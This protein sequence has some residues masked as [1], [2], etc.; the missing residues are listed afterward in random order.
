MT[1]TYTSHDGPLIEIVVKSDDRINNCNK[2]TTTIAEEHGNSSDEEMEIIAD[3]I[4][5]V[6]VTESADGEAFPVSQDIVPAG[7]YVHKRSSSSS[8]DSR[9]LPS[10][11]PSYD[12]HTTRSDRFSFVDPRGDDSPFHNVKS[13]GDFQSRLQKV[14]ETV[15]NR[16]LREQAGLSRPRS[17]IQDMIDMSLSKKKIQSSEKMLRT[18]F[19]EFY[20]GLGLLKSYRLEL[21]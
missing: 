6:E 9:S 11:E 3:F 14:R 4:E 13:K 17:I 8:Y 20:R 19:I 16:S 2:A 18:A 21:V 5:N 1:G 10:P 7:P 15:E 12:R